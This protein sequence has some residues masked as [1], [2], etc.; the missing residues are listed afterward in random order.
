MARRHARAEPT[1][2]S[3]AFLAGECER[4]GGQRLRTAA[5]ADC[6]QR[7]KPTETDPERDRR[8][9]LAQRALERERVDPPSEPFDD[10][11]HA[12]RELGI[13]TRDVIRF[14]NRASADASAE[15]SLLRAYENL[16]RQV[17]RAGLLLPRPDRNRSRELLRSALKRGRAMDLWLAALGAPTMIEAQRG[18]SAAQDLCDEAETEYAASPSSKGPHDAFSL[19][20]TD[21]ALALQHSKWDLGTEPGAGLLGDLLARTVTSF[22]AERVVELVSVARNLLHGNDLRPLVQSEEWRESEL[23]TNE[24]VMSAARGIL[25]RLEDELGTARDVAGAA[26]NLVGDMRESVAR[27]SVATLL[28]C[29]GF[30]DY[31]RLRQQEAGKT[32]KQATEGFPDLQLGSLDQRLRHAGAH[33]SVTVRDGRVVLDSHRDPISYSEADFLDAVLQYVETLWALSV[34]VGLAVRDTDTDAELVELLDVRQRIGLVEVVLQQGGCGECSAVFKETNLHAEVECLPE[35]ASTLAAAIV[36]VLPANID[37]LTLR[38]TSGD[39]YTLALDVV[40]RFH[41]SFGESAE[42]AVWEVLAAERLN[43][44]PISSADDWN[45]LIWH[46][47]ST[48]HGQPPR[49]RVLDLRRLAPVLANSGHPELMERL[50]EALSVA[51]SSDVGAPKL[52]ATFGGD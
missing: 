49:D 52:P 12:E 9:V 40:R 29:A 7:P 39:E 11:D 6:G 2:M 10:L 43:G 37:S 22:D 8:Q 44:E 27:H 35:K 1:K 30:G 5:C 47:L 17:A 21:Q 26:L 4:C 13:A 34:G 16:D 19:I 51:R 33:A 42:T 31:R 23:D 48:T 3:L 46:Q 45:A 36:P 32:L 50:R 38:T 25:L 28:A 15:D 24:T 20:D 18:A 14:L 41:E